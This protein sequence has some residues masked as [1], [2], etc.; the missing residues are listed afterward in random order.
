MASKN[1]GTLVV[2]MIIALIAFCV[3]AGIGVSMSMSD[4]GADVANNTTHVENV[5]QE[6]TTNLTD[7]N[8]VVVYDS[9][10]DQ[11]NYL[12]RGDTN[13]NYTNN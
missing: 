13:L 12:E 11:A 4:D 8:N 7:K 6:M 3:G 9:E 1:D 5:T 10:I 2:F